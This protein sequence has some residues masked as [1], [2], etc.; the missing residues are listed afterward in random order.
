MV[1]RCVCCGKEIPE[2]RQVCRGCEIE[3]HIV[4]E[5]QSIIVAK[6]QIRRKWGNPI[7]KK[8]LTR[9]TASIFLG[10][11]MFGIDQVLA[12][13][14]SGAFL[15]EEVSVPIASKSAAQRYI[16]SC[17]LQRE[18]TIRFESD[19]LPV[20]TAEELQKLA[21]EAARKSVKGNSSSGDYLRHVIE[22]G[23]YSVSEKE[24]GKKSY[25]MQILYKETAEETEFVNKSIQK[26]VGKAKRMKGIKKAK[27]LAGWVVSQLEYSYFGSYNTAY[28][29]MRYKRSKCYGYALLTQKLFAEAGFKCKVVLGTVPGRGNHAWNAI[30]MGKKW[31]YVDT[32]WMDSYGGKRANYDYFL[33]GQRKCKKERKIMKGYEVKGMS[34]KDYNI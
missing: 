16:R 32:C 7:L 31:Y 15:K 27:Y 22:N 30:K 18:R 9:F 20:D 5:E 29:A 12:A 14:D 26:A 6:M 3:Y 25:V 21:M 1:D 17:M 13:S 4:E 2:G 11:S 28:E 33:F 10:I 19:N 34:K 23:F 8:W 24:N